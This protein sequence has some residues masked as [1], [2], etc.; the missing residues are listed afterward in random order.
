M[1]E[2]RERVRPVTNDVNK[3]PPSTISVVEDLH[4]SIRQLAK[5]LPFSTKSILRMLQSEHYH[6]YHLFQLLQELLPHYYEKRVNFC[7][8]A[9]NMMQQPGLVSLVLFPMK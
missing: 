3:V 1:Y 6:P 4:K 9:Q 8:C 2:K 5:E 7:Q